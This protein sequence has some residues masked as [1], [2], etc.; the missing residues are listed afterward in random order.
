MME[1]VWVDTNDDIPDKRRKVHL[2]TTV[3][4]SINYSVRQYYA[5]ISK[6]GSTAPGQGP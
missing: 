1:N 2:G 3:Q 4:Q 6:E 5:D